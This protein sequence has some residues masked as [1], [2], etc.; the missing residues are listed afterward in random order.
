[1]A[2]DNLSGLDKEQDHINKLPFTA[3]AAPD[4]TESSGDSHE[5]RDLDHYKVSGSPASRKEVASYY[6]YYA[7]NN[8]IGSFQ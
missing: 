7:G 5:P 1:M 6:A 4:P 2:V 8:G 3:V